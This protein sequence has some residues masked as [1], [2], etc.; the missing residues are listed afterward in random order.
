[1][2]D[3]FGQLADQ[4]CA[5][6]PASALEGGMTKMRTKKRS[7]GFLSPDWLGWGTGNTVGLALVVAAQRQ[8]VVEAK[9]TSAAEQRS[10]AG[11][12]RD[13][14]LVVAFGEV[15]AFEEAS[16]VVGYLE[17]SSEMGSAPGRKRIRLEQALVS[18]GQRRASGSEEAEVGDHRFGSLAGRCHWQHF[19]VVL[20]I[21]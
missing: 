11:M 5:W 21:G 9:E 15:G 7:S 19:F 13:L 20:Q 10:S 18:S 6:A 17:A 1:M 3:L 4:V 8:T 2:E 12:R 14:A 16:S